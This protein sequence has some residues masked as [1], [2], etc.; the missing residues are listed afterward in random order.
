MRELLTAGALVLA[1]GPLVRL[2]IRGM[3][4]YPWLGKL[5]YV[6]KDQWNRDGSL[7]SSY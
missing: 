1:S 4:R 5:I 3:I 2:L 7:L 6:F